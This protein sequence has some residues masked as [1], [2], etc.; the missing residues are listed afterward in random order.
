MCTVYV[1]VYLLYK[2]ITRA[3]ACLERESLLFDL[4]QLP[5]EFQNKIIDIKN[6]LR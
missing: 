6:I 4:N 3:S 2:F 5:M 1:T